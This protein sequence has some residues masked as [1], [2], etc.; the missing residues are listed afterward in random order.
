MTSLENIFFLFVATC[1]NLFIK[2]ML[3]LK[4]KNDNDHQLLVLE[5]NCIKDY[6]QGLL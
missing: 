2:T 4:Q 1:Y 6:L 3:L 5:E